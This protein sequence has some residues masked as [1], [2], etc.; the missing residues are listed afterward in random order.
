MGLL[1][2]IK[3]WVD[4]EI[5]THTDLNAEVDNIIDNLGPDIIDDASANAGAM[6]ATEDPYPAEAISLSTILRRPR[7]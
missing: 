4:G 1:A 6:Q 3:T 5:L 2:R 7:S